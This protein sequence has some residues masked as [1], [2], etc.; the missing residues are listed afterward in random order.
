MYFT[1]AYI[2]NPIMY[3]YYYLYRFTNLPFP[4]VLIVSFSSMFKPEKNSLGILL[5]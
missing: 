1:P 5:V 3:Y 2:L 4:V